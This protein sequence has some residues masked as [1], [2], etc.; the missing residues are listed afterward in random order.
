MLIDCGANVECTPEYLLQFAY[1][2]SFYADKIMGCPRPRVGLLSNGT[3]PTK[4][5]PLQKQTFKLLQKASEAGRINFIGN[6][7]GNDVMAGGVDVVVT[8]GFT[9]NVFLKASEG[10]IK[11]ALGQLKNV[12][13]GSTK[14]KLAALALKRDF[15]AMRDG[16]DVNKIGGTALLGIS[17]PVIKAHGSSN[18]EAI[19]SAIRQAVNFSKAGV[20]EEIEKNIEH[21]RLDPD[22]AAEME[23]TK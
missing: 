17:R 4:G 6:V 22:E 20:I 1:M 13:Y 7:E 14:N 3:E 9:G 18:D 2:G 16:L 8:D 15:M 21:M 10:M 12:F 23:E 5:A 11:F 19:F